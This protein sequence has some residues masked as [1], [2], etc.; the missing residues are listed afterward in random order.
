MPGLTPLNRTTEI[1]NP[2][3]AYRL[4]PFAYRFFAFCFLLLALGLSRSDILL[5]KSQDKMTG[6]TPLQIRFTHIATK[7]PGLTPLNRTTETPNPPIAYRL[8]PIAYRF[9]LFAFCSWLF[10][11]RVLIFY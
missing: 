1:S 6:L 8:S 2:P 5:T 7:M 9:L 10:A 3:I 4:S 11:F